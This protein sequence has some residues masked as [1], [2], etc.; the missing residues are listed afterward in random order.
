MG[1]PKESPL[2]YILSCERQ[3]TPYSPDKHMNLARSV[4]QA[5][6]AKID[7]K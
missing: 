5:D 6:V 7:Q 4:R 1:L 2:H 3:N